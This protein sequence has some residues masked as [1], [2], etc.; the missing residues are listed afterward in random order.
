MLLLRLDLDLALIC[1]QQLD[2]LTQVLLQ[3]LSLLQLLRVELELRVCAINN[4]KINKGRIA[5]SSVLKLVK[6]Y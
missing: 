2:L 3:L 1:H 4:N 5:V 6:K